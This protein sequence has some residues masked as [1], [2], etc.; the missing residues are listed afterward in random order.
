MSTRKAKKSPK[1][2][3]P[4]FIIWFSSPDS[5]VPANRI[6]WRSLNEV[7][8]G[9][10]KTQL[11]AEKALARY[12]EQYPASPSTSYSVRKVRA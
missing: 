1:K 8:T 3:V 6:G 10:Y 2:A 12:L 9:T 7:T 4:Q 5:D 11:G